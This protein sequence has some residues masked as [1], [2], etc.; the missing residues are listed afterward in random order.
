MLLTKYSSNYTFF[1]DFHLYAC[2]I[3]FT[4]VNLVYALPPC[5]HEF[6]AV[7]KGQRLPGILYGDTTYTIRNTINK[8][9]FCGV[10][11]HIYLYPK[12]LNVE[13][14]FENNKVITESEF[15]FQFQVIDCQ[16][17]ESS[18]TKVLLYE[19]QQLFVANTTFTVI[20]FQYLVNK[21]SEI[22]LNIITTGNE[23]YIIYSGPIVDEQFKMQ[24]FQGSMKIPSFQCIIVIYIKGFPLKGKIK[25]TEIRQ[26][27]VEE[28]NV[29]PDKE[30]S[31]PFPNTMCGHTYGTLC[32]IKVSQ[33]RC[34]N[35]NV[36]TKM[37][38]NVFFLK[39]QENVPTLPKSPIT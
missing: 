33:R 8:Y 24:N 6:L 13:I 31:L 23:K 7:Q 19:P 28:I 26:P 32:I 22:I 14:I 37:V 38:T 21:F 30:I 39:L 17:V 18:T 5:Y 29:E 16:P 1:L 25:L 10:Q 3:T 34:L 4:K 20:T 35:T 11:S 27:A 2:N 12:D 15:S 9:Q 36:P